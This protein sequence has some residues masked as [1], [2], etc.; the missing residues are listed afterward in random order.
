MKIKDIPTDMLKYCIYI[1]DN[2]VIAPEHF[3]RMEIG[4]FI[5]H[6]NDPNIIRGILIQDDLKKTVV[7][8]DDSKIR[9]VF[10]IKEIKAGDEILID[11]NTLNEPEHLKESYFK[12]K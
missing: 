8:T 6:S 10:T 7:K 2:E 1:N 12:N 11:Y 3:D 4:W 5:N 9:T